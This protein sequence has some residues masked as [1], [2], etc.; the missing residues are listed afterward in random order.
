MRKMWGVRPWTRHGLILVVVGVLYALVGFQ[1]LNATPNINR[2]RALAV[3]LR[4]API[5]FWGGVFILAGVLTIMSSRWPPFAEKWGYVILTGLSA[6][7]AAA[8]LMGILFFHAPSASVT[9]VILWGLLSFMWWA[10]SGLLNPDKTA[11][12]DHERL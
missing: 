5:Q 12:T 9:Q 3:L 10:V 7:W 11:V 2:E 4:V 1:Y 6:G 8:Y